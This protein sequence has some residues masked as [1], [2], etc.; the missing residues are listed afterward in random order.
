MAVRTQTYTWAD[1]LSIA[2]RKSSRNIVDDYGTYIANMTL[3]WVWDK[4]D[5]R[6]SIA[7]LPTFYLV[8]N[9]QDY[10]AP[11]VVIPSDFY[12]LRWANL[13]R[14]D[15][16]PPYRQPLAIIKDLQTT[17]IRY[18][19]H[20]IGYVPEKQAFRLYPRVPDNIGSPVYLVEGVYKKRPT[21]LTASNLVTTLLPFDDIYFQ[22]WIETA[23]WVLYQS[24]NDPRAGVITS[25]NG[26]I[27]ATGQAATMMDMIEW[28]ASREG[29]ELG[30]PV[31]APAEPLVTQGPYR[32][33]MFGLGFSF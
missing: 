22:M 4:F 18:L 1:V 32:P 27:N 16:V 33:A 3:N 11:T 23:K 13:V 29:L 6:E 5:W 17:H 25:S 31:I 14:I 28:V 12:G 30:D 21:L 7:T 15:N 10:G 24:E 20:A 19:P 26:V 8:P 9:E 2:M